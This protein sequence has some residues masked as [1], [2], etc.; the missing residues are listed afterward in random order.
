MS[1]RKCRSLVRF[2]RGQHGLVA[3][4]FAVLVPV[5]LVLVFGIV[6][7]GHA[8]YMSQIV[9]NASR[10]GARYGITYRANS[11]GARL[12]PSAFSPTI[13]NYVLNSY[14]ARTSLPADAS[15]LVTSGGTG[16]STGA[17][18]APL[19]VTVTAT[20]NWFVMSIVPG[21]GTRKILAATTVM[22]CE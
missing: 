5:F 10:E 2:S 11:S 6:D 13:P 8:W 16:Y 3:V 19:E 1:L 7:L 22:Q 9:T 18:G 17:K 14:L 20:K 15:P 21:M 12:A 4:E